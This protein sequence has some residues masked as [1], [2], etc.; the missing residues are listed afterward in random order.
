MATLK[1]LAASRL[2][3]IAPSQVSNPDSI[4]EKTLKRRATQR[5]S[6]VSSAGEHGA[7][8]KR[9]RRAPKETTDKGSRGFAK[10]LLQR[11]MQSS[12]PPEGSRPA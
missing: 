4:P 7:E 10:F 9:Q 12:A 11:K 8:F 3:G 2:A 6:G 1:Q 5:A